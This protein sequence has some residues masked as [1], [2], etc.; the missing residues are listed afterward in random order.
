MKIYK[1]RKT[2][3]KS[4]ITL[5]TFLNI[6]RI[7]LTFVIVYMIIVEKPVLN[8]VFIFAIAAITDWLDGVIARKYNLV[9]DFGRKADMVADRFLWIGTALAII[10]VFGI[11]ARLESIHGVQLLFIMIREIITAPFASVAFFA[12]RGFPNVRYIAKIT[13]FLQGFAL[14]ALLLSIYYPA[15]IYLSLPLS[16]IIGVMGII[17][18]FYYIRDVQNIE[19]RK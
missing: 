3:N 11:R 9:N 14:P 1:R 10:T 6:S 7:I 18:G 13:T 15:W 12:G 16:I 8:I 5:P 19:E 17:S 4:I 2:E